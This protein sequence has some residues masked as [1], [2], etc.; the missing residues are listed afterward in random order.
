MLVKGGP[1][2]SDCPICFIMRWCQWPIPDNSV[3]IW[4]RSPCQAHNW[5]KKKQKKTKNFQLIVFHFFSHF[6]TLDI[7]ILR[8]WQT[9]CHFMMTSWHGSTSLNT[10]SPPVTDE[11]PSSSSN[12]AWWIFVLLEYFLFMSL[13]EVPVMGHFHFLFVVIL[14][15]L[16]TT[17]FSCWRFETW[18]HPFEVPVM[19]FNFCFLAGCCFVTFYTRKAALEAQN[20][21]HNIKTMPGVSSSVLSFFLWLPLLSLISLLSWLTLTEVS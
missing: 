12:Q 18:W 4:S 2:V 6:V 10:L 20:A 13:F 5:K 11:F 9:G 16:L 3:F 17:Q 8:L 14:K 21:L 15:K 1:G 7:N 19:S